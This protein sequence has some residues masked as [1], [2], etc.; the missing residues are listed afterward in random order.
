[1]T[2]T[3]SR[4]NA[5]RTPCTKEEAL[6]WRVKPRTQWWLEEPVAGGGEAQGDAVDAPE[7]LPRPSHDGHQPDGTWDTRLATERVPCMPSPT[8]GGYAGIVPFAAMGGD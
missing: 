7:A 3:K 2:T 6:W 1:M 4:V 5:R 8:C